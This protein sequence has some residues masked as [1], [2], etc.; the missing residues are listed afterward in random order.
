VYA[1]GLTYLLNDQTDKASEVLIRLVDVDPDTVE[2][3][4]VLGSLFRRRGEVD[5]AIAV[6]QNIIDR[7]ESDEVL[8]DQARLELGR[9]FLKAGLL[10]RAEQLLLTLLERRR[11]EKA[12]CQHLIDVYQQLKEWEKALAIG[13]RL[14]SLDSEA[15]KLQLAQYHCEI[16][17][18]AVQRHDLDAAQMEA[19]QARIEDP[20]CVR[21]TLLMGNV[22]QQK[23]DYRAAIETYRQV[24]EQNAGLMPEVAVQIENCYERL[25]CRESWEDYLGALLQRHSDLE[26]LLNDQ[27]GQH[28]ERATGR[29]ARYCCELCGFTSSKLFWQCPGCQSWSSVKPSEALINSPESDC[30]QRA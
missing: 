8:R 7:S 18:V 10:D 29:A 27:S 28:L 25:G 23:G 12:V 22:L 3:H 17:E 1:Q 21:A 5:R 20:H 6:H 16:A 11:Y 19:K 24:E 4:L 15:W 2:L 26:F 30:T 9:D 14:V 13:E